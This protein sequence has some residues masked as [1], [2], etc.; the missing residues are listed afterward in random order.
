M[1][2][3][4]LVTGIAGWI[5]SITAQKLIEAGYEVIGVDN[6]S[7]GNID[8]VPSGIDFYFIDIADKEA[9]SYVFR[10]HDIKAV[11]H[12]AGSLSVEESIEDPDKYYQNNTEN[13]HKLLQYCK[14]FNVSSI[15][16]SSTAAVYGEILTS[17]AVSESTPCVPINP[18]GKSKLQAE[19]LIQASGMNYTILR[20]FNVAGSGQN[21][22]SKNLI[23]MACKAAL[24][25]IPELCIFGFNYPTSD[26]TAVRDYIHVKDLAD[27]HV[28]ALKQTLKPK[29]NFQEIINV[30]Y[31]MGFSI[32]EVLRSIA[33]HTGEMPPYKFCPAREGDP[34]SVIADNS[35][36]IRLLKWKPKYS[37]LD[38][39]TDESLEWFE[40]LDNNCVI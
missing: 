5:G 21:N 10:T 11:L 36:A 28:L 8:N 34:A 4:V 26:K 32:L 30:G 6:L 17:D 16:F 14:K 33:R 12:F 39:I 1:K 22:D 7:T 29:Q 9:M 19:K 13:T 20:Y 27:A 3:K 24:G 31:G 37:R 25:Q 18:Y 40:H 23:K 15:V 35:K 38:L 2:T